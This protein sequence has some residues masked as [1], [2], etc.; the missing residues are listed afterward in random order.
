MLDGAVDADVVRSPADAESSL[1]VEISDE[2]GEG[3]VCRPHR[4]EP[5]A[6]REAQASHPRRRRAP[7][8]DQHGGHRPLIAMRRQAPEGRP[9][10]RRGAGETTATGVPWPRAARSRGRHG[11]E[12]LARVRPPPP[13]PS[14]VPV[15]CGP[16]GAWGGP[17]GPAACAR[18]AAAAGRF[19]VLRL[20][21]M[22]RRGPWTICGWTRSAPPTCAVLIAAALVCGSR[23]STVRTGLATG[24]PLGYCCCFAWKAPARS[25]LGCR[26]RCRLA[27]HSPT[28][29]QSTS[30]N[31]RAIRTER[32]GRAG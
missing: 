10:R 18:Q 20:A 24:L 13:P 6:R 28:L 31:A 14:W 2:V 5:R 15:G 9:R 25:L 17:P 32:A 27:D 21:A 3:A 22:R 12:R 11:L 26:S 16:G 30:C 7:R 29:A 8:R 4:A 19:S 23:P 1:L